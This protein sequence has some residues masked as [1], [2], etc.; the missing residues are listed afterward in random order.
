M[1]AP[2]NGGHQ[3]KMRRMPLAPTVMRDIQPC[4]I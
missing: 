1:P 3:L 2:R 4:D